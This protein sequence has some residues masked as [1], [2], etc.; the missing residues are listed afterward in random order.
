MEWALIAAAAA[1]VVCFF[2]LRRRPSEE[3]KVLETVAAS[4]SPPQG[5]AISLAVPSLPRDFE[6]ALA[7]ALL[8]GRDPVSVAPPVGY[9]AHHIGVSG[10]TFD[11]PNGSSRQEI[12]AETA[13]GTTVYL[14]PEPDNPHDGDAIRVFVSKGGTATAQVGYLPRGHFDI[15]TEVRGGN[16][17]AWF[18]SKDRAPNGAWG[19]VLYLVRRES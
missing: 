13:P 14:V 9:R 19:A 7:N 15:V 2:F 3:G 11:N 8:E 18:A 5:T 17:A 10:E 1:F 12:I 6:E 4:P 16:I